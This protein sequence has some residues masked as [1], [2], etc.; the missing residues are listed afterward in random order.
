MNVLDASA[1]ID[2][3]A[4]RV[5]KPWVLD[6]PEEPP[7]APAHQLVEVLSAVTRLVRGGVLTEQP[8]PDALDDAA[9]L[10]RRWDSYRPGAPTNC[11]GV[12]GSST[13][14]S[15]RSPTSGALRCSRRTAG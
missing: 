1:P 13:A 12:F 14:S 15:W 9:A 7:I 3:A 11:E 8:R 4:D 6:H 2:V 5:T 10:R